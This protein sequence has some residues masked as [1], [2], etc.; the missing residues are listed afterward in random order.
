MLDAGHGGNGDTGAIGPLGNAGYAEKDVALNI[1]KKLQ[2][3]L[4]ELG[5][6]VIMTRTSDTFIS[7]EDRLK[8]NRTA[9]PDLF[10]S[11]HLN[12]VEVNTNAEKITGLGAWYSKELSLDI[13]SV[14]SS[15]VTSALGRYNRKTNNSN[16]YVCRGT[17]CPALILETG[18]I[19]CPTEFE[20]LVN[21]TS[22]TQLAASIASSLVDY[23]R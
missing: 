6:N 7:L 4:L 13:S 15:K 22:Q 10:L 2:S 9:K 18:F 19:C 20:W 17:W 23:Y 16:L 5:A 1:T 3:K 11:I 8:M 12:A 14:L 21:E